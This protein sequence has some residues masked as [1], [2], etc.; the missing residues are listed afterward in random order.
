MMVID[1]PCRRVQLENVIV[2]ARRAG[3]DI[4]DDQVCATP[5]ERGHETERTLN[6]LDIGW[7]DLV[8]N[9]GRFVFAGP[10]PEETSSPAGGT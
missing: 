2:V 5:N 10:T 6:Q 7:M 4:G 9:V 1:E 8:G 3:G